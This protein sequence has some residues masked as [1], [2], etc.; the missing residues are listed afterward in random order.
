MDYIPIPDPNLAKNQKALQEIWDLL[1]AVAV[2]VSHYSRS[3]FDLVIP[4]TDRVPPATFWVPCND[5]ERNIGLRACLLVWTAT[6]SELVLRELGYIHFANRD[7][8]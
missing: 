3:F 7:H 1:V 6:Y 2:A 8:V 4:P 5:D